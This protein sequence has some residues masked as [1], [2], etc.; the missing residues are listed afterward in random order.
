MFFLITQLGEKE[1]MNEN[2]KILGSNL[3]SIPDALGDGEGLGRVQ[4]DRPV[5]R[6]RRPDVAFR[7]LYPGWLRRRLDDR[8]PEVVDVV[9]EG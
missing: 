4:R 8:L 6:I 7:A 5:D 1:K 3:T 9:L 2:P